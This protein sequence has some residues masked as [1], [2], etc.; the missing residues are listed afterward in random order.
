[1][2]KKKILSIANKMISKKDI[3]LFDSYP[4]FCDNSYALYKL[5]VICC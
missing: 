5:F 1:M 2:D 3:I 4:D